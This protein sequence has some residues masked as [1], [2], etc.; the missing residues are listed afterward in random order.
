MQTT[1]NWKLVTK[2]NKAKYHQFKTGHELKQGKIFLV[3]KWSRSVTRQNVISWKQ[4]TKCNKTKCH[5]LKT[6]HGV[7][8]GKYHRLNTVHE[9]EQGK[10]S[11]VENWSRSG[12]R[13]NIISWKLVTKC[14]KG[15]QHR[16]KTGHEVEPVKYHQLKT[17]HEVEQGKISLVE[18]WT[19]SGKMQTTISWKL[20]T[21]W[22]KAKYSQLKT[23]HEV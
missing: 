2:W 23:G 17:G 22:N 7:E 1:I 21:K 13:R 4:V 6:G 19:R 16:L 12:T 8:P 14:T 15:K 11:S 3:E 20:V 5:R 10:I 18:K 9:V